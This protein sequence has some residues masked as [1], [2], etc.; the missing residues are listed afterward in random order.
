MIPE[1]REKLKK[2]Q[3]HYKRNFD[4]KLWKKT[5][6]IQP[7]DNAFL[8]I[9]RKD[10]KKTQR[11][12]APIS[13]RPL[14]VM[15]VDI[16]DNAVIIK[17]PD[18]SVEKVSRSWVAVNPKSD[19]YSHNDKELLPLHRRNIIRNYPAAVKNLN[20]VPKIPSTTQ[21]EAERNPLYNSKVPPSR[22][23]TKEKISKDTPTQSTKYQVD[24]DN[25]NHEVDT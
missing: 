2:A 4:K 6:T 9:E 11:K 14:A 17:R 15:H 16:S 25:K 7:N 19:E 1:T 21:E 20:Q 8:Q 12:F 22:R 13:E 3:E 5:E 24:D 18:E 10:K 23:N